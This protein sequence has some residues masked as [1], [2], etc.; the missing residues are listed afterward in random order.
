LFVSVIALLV[1]F[2]TKPQSPLLY[3]AILL[4]AVAVFAL[5]KAAESGS[6]GLGM[7][8]VLA[9][10]VGAAVTLMGLGIWLAAQGIAAMLG[11]LTSVAPGQLFAL[12]GALLALATA[13]AAIA[14]IMMMPFVSLGLAVFALGLFAVAEAFKHISVEKISAFQNFIDQ[15]KDVDKR[16]GIN[17]EVIGEGIEEIADSLDEIPIAKSI[18]LTQVLGKMTEFSTA[19]TPVNVE[20]AKE[21][22]GIIKEIAEVKIGLTSAILWNKAVDNLI[23]VMSAAAGGGG[24]GGGGAAAASPTTIVL[25]LDRRQLGRTVVDLVN[26]RYNLRTAG[27]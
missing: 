20:N 25:E 9:L 19:V 17:F 6:F 7:L 1:A 8:A 22:T 3:V 4:T 14:L 13:F 21:M 15:I 27:T 23:R 18:A 2:L 10:A 12:A 26:E 11:S 16:V 5:G 24:A